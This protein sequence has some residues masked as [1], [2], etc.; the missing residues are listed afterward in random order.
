MRVLTTLA[1]AGMAQSLVACCP[2]PVAKPTTPVAV[3]PPTPTPTKPEEPPMPPPPPPVPTQSAAPQELVFPEEAFRATQ[4]PPTAERPFRLPKVQTLK[5]KNGIT[6]YLVE[7]HTLP[8]V[9]FDLALTGGSIA[10]PAGKEGLASVCM[11]LVGEG[12]EKLDKIAYSEALADLASSVSTYASDDIQGV[13]ASTLSKH[14]DETFALFADTVRTPGLRAEDL[15]RL[16]KRRVEGVKQQKGAPSSVA[17]RVSGPVLYGPGHRYGRPVTEA[18]LSAITLDDCKQWHAH[19][20]KPRGA[21]LFVVGDMTAAQLRER[22]DGPALAGFAGAPPAAPTLPAPKALP[23]R[24]FLVH[25]PGAAQSVVSMLEFGPRRTAPDFLATQI[26]ASVL[27]GGFASRLNMNLREDKGYSYGAG[28]GFSYDRQRSVLRATASVRTDA[29]YQ[30]LLEIEKELRALASG[31]AP[32]TAEELDR[33]KQ[34]AILGLPARFATGSAALGNYRSLVYFGLPLDY[35]DSF[36]AK[37]KQVGQKQVTAA[38]KQHI[39]LGKAVYVVVGDGDAPVIVNTGKN[40][41]EPYLIDGKPATLRQ[42]LAKL[43]ADGT[44]GTGGLVT[45]DTDG[46]IIP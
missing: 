44:L 37:V 23:G 12:T 10:E 41:N 3:E 46:A 19:W 25:T 16:I 26:M 40:Q 28:G 6:A 1:L 34:G 5:L 15:D 24:I 36:I 11:S 17:G 9:S 8:I 39:D 43:A 35:F 42:A 13:G 38:A 4:P 22:F 7:S 18:S 20:V 29:S 2:K 33:E 31:K 14:L 45:L 21:N 27:G 30:S 32:T